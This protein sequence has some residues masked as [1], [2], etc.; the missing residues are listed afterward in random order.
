[1]M[2]QV[3]INGTMVFKFTNRQAAVKAFNGMAGA[4]NVNS[5]TLVIDG[6]IIHSIV[7]K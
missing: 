2:I 6:E 7:R 4:D 1:M 3:E 5:I